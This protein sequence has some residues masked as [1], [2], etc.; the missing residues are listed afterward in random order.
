MPSRLA[1]SPSESSMT[2]RFPLSRWLHVEVQ[3]KEGNVPLDP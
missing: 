1:I 2:T 3:L